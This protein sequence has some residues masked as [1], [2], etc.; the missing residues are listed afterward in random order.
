MTCV[1]STFGSEVELAVRLLLE[2]FLEYK[3]LHSR[4]GRVQEKEVFG[5]VCL[6]KAERGTSA[7]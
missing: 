3:A 6:E 5:E 2:L 1:R 7:V 4:K